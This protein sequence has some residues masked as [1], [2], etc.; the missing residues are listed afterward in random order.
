MYTCLDKCGHKW[1]AQ[2]PYFIANTELKSIEDAY[3]TKVSDSEG[4]KVLIIM[5]EYLMK[6]Q[7]GL[8]K[9]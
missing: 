2:N 9:N 5:E 4:S 8:K 3:I 1:K 7:E 6:D